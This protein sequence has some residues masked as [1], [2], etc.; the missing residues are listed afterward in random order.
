M[1]AEKRGLGSGDVGS[2]SPKK[3]RANSAETLSPGTTLPLPSK[4]IGVS[5]DPEYINMSDDVFH[6]TSLAS[7]D[8]HYIHSLSVP[9]KYEAFDVYGHADKNSTVSSVYFGK[10]LCG[11]EGIVHGGCISTVL[12]ELFGWTMFWMTED[13]GFTANLNVNFRKPLP[14]DTFGLIYTKFDKRERRK[15]YMKSRLEDNDGNLYAEATTL[16]ILPKPTE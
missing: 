10:K 15:V 3:P 6:N 11:H 1:T 7:S 4:M 8:T 16:F 12:D 5:N 2:T 13:V 14:V 9:G